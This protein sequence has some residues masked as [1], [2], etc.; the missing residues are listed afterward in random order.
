MTTNNELDTNDFF[1]QLRKSKEEAISN[2]TTVTHNNSQDGLS[3]G[4]VTQQVESALNQ[5]NSQVTLKGKDR[6][7]N[8]LDGSNENFKLRAQLDEI[9][10]TISGI[11]VKGYEIFRGLL[12]QG[13]IQVGQTRDNVEEVSEKIKQIWDKLRSS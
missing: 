7:G 2:E 12:E 5:G 11:A 4:K 1:R 6:Q 9:P 8:K 13:T 3:K 10:L